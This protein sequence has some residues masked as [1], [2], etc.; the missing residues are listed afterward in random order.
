MFYTYL[1]IFIFPVVFFIFNLCSHPPPL[2]F[3][4]CIS[5]SILALPCGPPIPELIITSINS[6]SEFIE[7]RPQ[8]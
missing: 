2:T 7:F 3:V 5:T 6:A 8:F 4:R 1:F